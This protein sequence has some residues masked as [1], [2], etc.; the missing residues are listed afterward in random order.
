MKLNKATRFALF[1]VLELANSPERHLSATEIANK[2]EISVHHLVKVL[3]S[4][5]RSRLVTSVRGAGGGYRFIGNKKRTTLLDIAEVFEDI[6]QPP[7]IPEEGDDT[8]IGIALS[9]IM[10]EIDDI[11][12]ATLNSISIDTFLKTMHYYQEDIPQ[13][14][15]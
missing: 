14:T 3:H 9:Q 13:P 5:V 1:A 10:L 15:I 6:R 2:Y 4:L 12:I 8:E 7:V 11:A